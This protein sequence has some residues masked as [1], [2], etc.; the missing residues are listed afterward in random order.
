MRPPLL[1]C[2]RGVPSD[3]RR[4]G[5]AVVGLVALGLALPAGADAAY[6]E[7]ANRE[8]LADTSAVRVYR[9][10]RG[11]LEDR[12]FACLKRNGRKT[13]LW[14]HGEDVELHFVEPIRIEGPLVGFGAGTIGRA[15]N[16]GTWV[17][18]IDTRTRRSLFSRRERDGTRILDLELTAGGSAGW[19]AEDGEGGFP[20]R[21]LDGLGAADLDDGAGVDPQSLTLSGSELR[22]TKSGEPRSAP[23][24]P[25]AGTCRPRARHR[26]VETLAANG[27]VRV[28]KLVD[29]G[30]DEGFEDTGV[31]YACDRAT[32]WRKK[33]GLDGAYPDLHEVHV[34]LEGGLV[35]YST[36]CSACREG[37]R[38]PGRVAVL[39]VP[40]HRHSY[41][42]RHSEAGDGFATDLVLKPNGSIGW[43]S[44]DRLADGRFGH[45]VRRHDAGGL[46][47]LDSGR[48]IEPESLT[49]GADS[50]LRWVHG[51]EERSAPLR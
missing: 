20:V 17:E 21:R 49:L 31:V 50:T 18:V 43:I 8:T 6:C 45:V 22:W 33:L 48:T 7:A 46:A 40:A 13:W 24:A 38:F 44:A 19:I 2:R 16:Q 47:D 9:V 32:G 51:G 27:L 1:R 34:R 41:V 4:A 3:V 35:A 5:A 28:Y 15:H 26:G 14:F 10:T 39:D 42:F 23:I 30:H 37:Y 29:A 25:A 36:G 11:E 12:V